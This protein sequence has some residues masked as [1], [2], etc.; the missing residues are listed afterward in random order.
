MYLDLKR[1]ELSGILQTQQLRSLE[2]E[3]TNVSSPVNLPNSIERLHIDCS[4]IEFKSL[5][6]KIESFRFT[7]RDK[8]INAPLIEIL[9]R[10][11]QIEI[12]GLCHIKKTR[13]SK[14]LKFQKPC[15]NLSISDCQLD[16]EFRLQGRFRYGDLSSVE[17]N[18]FCGHIGEGL[19]F[20]ELG[21]GPWYTTEAVLELA[22]ICHSLHVGLDGDFP[23]LSNSK[24]K[25]LEISGWR[26][27]DRKIPANFLPSSLETI[28]P[29][30]TKYNV[31]GQA[32][33]SEFI[34]RYCS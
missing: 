16:P 10:D 12:E 9:S 20:E 29:A 23:D 1:C 21:A 6:R 26:N 14:S 2:I 31:K 27:T 22:Q 24:L 19:F 30:V 32:L 34:E 5:P 17:Q 8:T 15:D 7:G 18:Y 25:H 4:Q 33:P 11:N 28:T 13:L 3:S